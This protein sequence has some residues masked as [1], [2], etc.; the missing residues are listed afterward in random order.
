MDYGGYT[1]KQLYVSPKFDNYKEEILEHI[2]VKMY[3]NTVLIKADKYMQS[4]KVREIHANRFCEMA[5]HYGIERYAPITKEHIISMILYTDFS[6]YCTKFSGTFRKSAPYES[7]Y[8]VKARNAEFYHQ[9]KLFRECVELYTHIAEF[10][11]YESGPFYSGVNCVLAMPEFALRLSAP[12]ST[13]KHIE[14]SMNFAKRKG[15]GIQLNNNGHVDASLVRFFDCSWLSQYPDEDERV[16]AGLFVSLYSFRILDIVMCE[17]GGLMTINVESVRIV[18]TRQN[19]EKLFHA[20]FIFDSM[21]TDCGWISTERTDPKITEQDMLI[22]KELVINGTRLH[23]VDPYIS[24][25]IESYRRSK[26]KVRLNL[27][28]LDEGASK[29]HYGSFILDKLKEFDVDSDENE[30]M[31]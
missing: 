26:S 21:V 28:R 6:A 17:T 27:S 19:F 8:N 5:L 18:D 31:D 12:A 30:V 25:M 3:D 15:M 29:E 22:L 13:S 7:I 16:F 1:P 9:S 4:F 23:S 11:D 14:V 10:Y 24:S 2:D 20:L